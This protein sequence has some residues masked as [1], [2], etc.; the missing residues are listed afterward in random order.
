MALAE[1]KGNRKPKGKDE[2]NS[3]VAAGFALMHGFSATNIGKNR[4]T[5]CG[6]NAS[7]LWDSNFILDR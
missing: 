4:L 1:V 7:T 3:K 5:V 2:K 6:F